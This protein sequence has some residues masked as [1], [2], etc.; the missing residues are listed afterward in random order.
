M[1]IQCMKCFIVV[2]FLLF[3]SSICVG[4][5]FP[6]RNKYPDVPV[7]DMIDV[8]DSYE[9]GDILFV[10][11]RTEKEFDTIHPVSAVN[12]DFSQ[13]DY[14]GKLL[15]LREANP[16]KKIAVYGDGV[17]CLKSYRAVQ[18]ATDE[19][20]ENVYA[21]DAG[22]EAWIASYPSDT[23]LMG[24]QIVDTNLQ[25]ITKEELH[26][27]TLD[28]DQFK[29]KITESPTSSVFDLRDP[30]NKKKKIP[31]L[32]KVIPISLEKFI[33]NVIS[34]GNMKDKQLFIFDQAGSQIDWLT[35]YLTK[36]GYSNFYI[37]NGGAM[38]ILK[39]HAP[40]KDS[41]I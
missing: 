25:L 30:L 29:Q 15:K 9:R 14:L 27:S 13:D 2:L 28:F 34:K 10:D 38:A 6:Y 3:V 39:D 37:L 8:R 31:G 33:R 41:E 18:D 12:I 22:V 36:E 32:E 35:N 23:I 20:M 24:Q 7:I 4:E 40:D 16:G 17:A 1:N 21:Y 19:G 5:E 26:N 11:T